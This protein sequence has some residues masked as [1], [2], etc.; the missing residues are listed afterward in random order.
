MYLSLKD[1]LESFEEPTK[2]H[3]I[4]YN[5]KD[6]YNSTINDFDGEDGH[7]VYLFLKKPE[8]EYRNILYIGMSGTMHDTG[9]MSKQTIKKRL[10]RKQG[11][12]MRK[13][14]VPNI[15]KKKGETSIY[16]RY[17]ITF[18][19]NGD[20]KKLPVYIEATLMQDYFENRNDLPPWNKSF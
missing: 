1:I 12:E 3:P 17:F 8:M 5:V 18:D 14:W 20:K 19:P 6:D 11:K 16:I 9:K 2:D 13:E 7:G 10:R 4:K 15:M